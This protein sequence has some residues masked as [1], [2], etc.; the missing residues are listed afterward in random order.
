LHS[1]SSILFLKNGDRRFEALMGA[2]HDRGY[3]VDA[4]STADEAAATTA[5][6]LVA[7]R[8]YRAVIADLSPKGIDGPGLLR[9]VAER[10][11]ESAFIA[12]AGLDQEHE[13]RKLLDAG[14]AAYFIPPFDAAEVVSIIDSAARK[15]AGRG[16]QAGF[17][18]IVGAS[19]LIATMIELIGKVADVSS[20]V[21]V[22]GE[23][24]T[25]KELVARA[26]HSNSRRA[27]EPFVVV[28]CGAIPDGLLESELFGHERGAFTGAYS[29]KQGLFQ[30]ARGGTV[31]L[32]EIGEVTPATQ[33]KLLRVLESGMVRPVGG[34][35]DVQVGSRVIAATN[36]D[37]REDVRRG[38]FREDLFYRLNVFPIHVPSLRERKG[39][40]P[41]VARHF[42]ERI[43]RDR[44]GRPV[45]I[46]EPAMK[47]LAEYHWPGNIRELENV[48]ERAAI[49]S[50]GGPITEEYLPREIHASVSRPANPGVYDLPFKTARSAF[51]RDYVEHVL[52]RCEGN[53]A[54]AAR[55]AGM[56]R[57]YFYEVLERYGVRA[58]R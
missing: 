13:A 49:L 29:Q 45:E 2:L 16:P 17:C 53:V 3:A 28:H 50:S 27:A 36:R 51:E 31:F 4:V 22:T 14:A 47:L 32:D 24:G 41:L 37:L 46:A 15:P 52:N 5:A 40:I 57:A 20:T 43:G 25:G 38:T 56:S 7:E 11:P 21:L 9:S 48:I 1:S 8:P 44:G 19:P 54:R 35:R 39:D 10:S 58:A 23:S 26:I 42:L 55:M 6:A 34:T 30:S 12:I 18:G 33:V